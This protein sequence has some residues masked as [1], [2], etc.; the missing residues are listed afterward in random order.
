V[1]TKWAGWSG[2]V[3]F[4]REPCAMPDTLVVAMP[5]GFGTNEYVLTVLHFD[6]AGFLL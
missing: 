6:A 4:L 5:T 1:R 3:S 2:S